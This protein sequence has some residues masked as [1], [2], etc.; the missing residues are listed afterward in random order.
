MQYRLMKVYV[1]AD[2]GDDLSSLLAELEV[3]HFRLQA[4]D[5]D[6]HAVADALIPAE[7]SEKLTDRIT[8]AFAESP[9]FRVLLFAVEAVIPAPTEVEEEKQGPGEEEENNERIG[10]EELYQN[11]SEG[12]RTSVVY[13]VTV[14]LSAVVA[15]IGLIKGD[16]AVVIGAMVIVPLLRPNV[17]LALACTLGDY[18]LAGRS[19]LTSAVGVAVAVSVAFIMGMLLAVDPSIPAIA[20][21]TK[22]EAGDVA[23]AL[24]AGSAGALAF[25]TGVPA[26]LIGVMVAV[27]LLP[28]LVASGLLAGAG[29]FPLAFGAAALTLTNV[30]CVNLA[31]VV[32]FLAQG[33]HPRRWSEKENAHRATAIAI[34]FW[35]ATL[36]VLLIATFWLGR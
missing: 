12:S 18:K 25:T 20:S 30:A 6:A 21:R 7:G 13:I 19:I 14:V 4:A 5:G 29:M 3:E 22:V 28:P 34:T 23:L 11:I 17:A 2:R 9:G 10:R 27:A 8:D 33:I 36:A 1:P 24:A 31:G 26:A 32:T 15:A 16:T 35:L